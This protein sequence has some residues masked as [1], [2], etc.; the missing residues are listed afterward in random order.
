MEQETIITLR[1]TTDE[2]TRWLGWTRVQCQLKIR[3]QSP[4]VPRAVPEEESVSLRSLS[5]KNAGL[6]VHI[7][8]NPP[9]IMQNLGACD[10][11][12]VRPLTEEDLLTRHDIIKL[13]ETLSQLGKLQMLSETCLSLSKCRSVN[14]AWWHT[15]D[16]LTVTVTCF[17]L[18]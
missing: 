7:K 18:C 5:D 9:Q 8:V 14:R 10:V 13:G 6:L 4:M 17:Q 11:K 3:Q 2:A 1:S 12:K 16:E 15:S